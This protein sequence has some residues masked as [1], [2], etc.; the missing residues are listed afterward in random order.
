MKLT[1]IEVHNF[2]SI[3]DIAIEVNPYSLIVGENNSG[4]TNLLSALRVFYEESGLKFDTKRDFPKF[5]TDDKESWIELSFLTTPEEQDSLKEEYRSADRVLKVRKYLQSEH[6]LVQSKQSNIYSYENGQLSNNLF[7]GAANVSTS[8]LGSVIYI[9]AV[10]KVEDSMKTT[11]PSPFRNMV[12]VVMKKAIASSESFKTLTTAFNE[13]N[14]VFKQ[15]EISGFSI[16]GVKSEINSELKQWG[17]GFDIEVSPINTDDLVKSLLKPHIEDSNLGERVDISSFGQGLQRHLIYTL[18]KLSAKYSAK[19]KSTKKDFNPDFSLILFEEPEAFLHPAQQDVLYRSLNKLVSDEQ[20]QVLVSTHS[21]VF[22]SKSIDSINSIS[23]LFKETDSTTAYQITERSLKEILSNNLVAARVHGEDKSPEFDE[24]VRAADEAIKYFLWLDTERSNLFFA[25]HVLLC[26]GPSEKVLLDCLADSDWEFLREQRV[27]I[28]DC[29][30]KFNLHRFMHLL[31]VLGIKHSVLFDG[32]NDAVNKFINHKVWNGI[33]QGAK[34]PCT[35]GLHQF[36]S[37]LE[38]FLQIPK[39]DK[40]RSDLK[41]INVL[42]AHHENA[43]DAGRLSMLKE[44]I[45][46]LVSSETDHT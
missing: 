12:N 22:V 36:E 27:Y 39:P 34:T 40:K 45:R 4:K 9:P 43:L 25:R 6:G 30:G 18:I 20:Q 8:K 46:D 28:L 32:D 3:K 38:D 35:T 17:V 1:K 15:E 42:K 16:D 19:T 5:S 11:G 29:V 41:P 21:S 44:V 37:D 14:K 2:R 33:I 23:R 24:E 13:F 31:N 26:E 10:S 7:Y